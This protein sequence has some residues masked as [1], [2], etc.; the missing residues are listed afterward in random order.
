MWG[1]ILKRE[2]DFSARLLDS[3]WAAKHVV[4]EAVFL[5]K[6]NAATYVPESLVEAKVVRAELF[7]PTEIVGEENDD[8][9][10]RWRLQSLV[11]VK[12]GERRQQQ[13]RNEG[14]CYVGGAPFIN[15]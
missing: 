7:P 3:V 15:A 5:Q 9:G 13:N 11:R 6:Q 8:V 10:L 2:E 4:E 1:A 14:E 12:D